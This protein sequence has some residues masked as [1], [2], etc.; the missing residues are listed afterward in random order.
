MNED[1]IHERKYGD[2]LRKLSEQGKGEENYLSPTVNGGT[3]EEYARALLSNTVR[4][5]I[6]ERIEGK[7]KFI[8]TAKEIGE[9][10]LIDL[11]ISARTNCITATYSLECDA[12]FHCLKKI[13]SQADEISFQ[14]NGDK[15]LFS[16]TY[17]T[18]ATYLSGRKVSPLDD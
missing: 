1:I 10:Y 12:D 11:T 13:I 6:P 5:M 15:V 3:A 16:L 8:E 2:I 4:V 14:S 17:Y 9:E 18:H 7:V